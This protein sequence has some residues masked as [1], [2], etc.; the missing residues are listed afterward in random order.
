MLW[1]CQECTTL[2]AVGLPRCPQCGA[3]AHAEV[4][5]GGEP[6]GPRFE[7]DVEPA[8]PVAGDAVPADE[9]PA[10]AKANPKAPTSA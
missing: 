10:K 1:K 5:S 4:D 9:P 3:T 7:P 2:Y 8:E 6:V